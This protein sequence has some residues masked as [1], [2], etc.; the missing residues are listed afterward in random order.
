MAFTPAQ[1]HEIE[2]PVTLIDQV[3]RVPAKEYTWL[4]GQEDVLSG[5]L[6]ILILHNVLAAITLKT[7]SFLCGSF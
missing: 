1:N 5:T 4:N 2:L 3:P 7:L 6:C